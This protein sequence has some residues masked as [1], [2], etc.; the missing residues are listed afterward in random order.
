MTSNYRKGKPPEPRLRLSLLPDD[1][2]DGMVR[3]LIAAALLPV[4]LMF[5]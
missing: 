5:C 3:L 2:A 1:F 4:L